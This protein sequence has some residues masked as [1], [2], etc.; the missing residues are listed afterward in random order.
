MDRLEVQGHAPN[1]PE[2]EKLFIN[3]YAPLDDKNVVRDKL[4]QLQQYGFVQKYIS[5]FDNVVVA[6]PELGREDFI[7]IFVYGLKPLLKGFVKAW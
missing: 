6:L 4:H 7:H 2:F 1:F 5:A 3:Q